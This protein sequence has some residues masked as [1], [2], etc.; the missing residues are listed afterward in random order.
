M[1]W[2]R[3]DWFILIA[4]LL[5]AGALRFYQL[6][7][8]PPGPQFDEAFNAIDAEQIL[9][10]NRPLFLPANAGREPL[11][12]YLQAGVGALF[13]LNL[14]T[15]RLVSALAGLLTV[16]ALYVVVRLLFRRHSRTLAT[17]TALALTVSLWHIHFS[18][19]GIRVSLMPL[20]YCGLFG[21]LWFGLGDRRRPMRM[22][23]LVVAG[24][25]AGLSVWTNPTGR[26]TPFI[27][28]GYALYMFWRRA[29]RRR[30]GWDN[31]LAGAGIV[32]AA[33]LLV[34]L[35][36]GLEFWRHPAFFFGHAAEVSVF[37]DR[38]SGANPAWLTLLDHAV[39]VLGMFSFFGDPE[40]IHGIPARPVFDWFMA[41]PF[42]IGLAV[43][44]LRLANR[45]AV[46]PDPD[47]DALALFALWGAVMLLPSILSDAPPNFSRTLPAI[48]AVMLAAG[49]GL[50]WIATWP[51]LGRR[52]GPIL[53]AALIFASGAT[54]V[55][56]YFVRFANA[57][58]VYYAY[59]ADK[60]DAVAWLRGQAATATVLFAPL[61]AEHP[62]MRFLGDD[63]F[64]PVDVTEVTVLP[65]P[66]Q[67]IVYAYPAEQTDFVEAVADDWGAPVTRVP[68]RH[69]APLLAVVQLTAQQA[70]SWPLDLAP[71]QMTLARFDD[72]PTLLGMRRAANGVGFA[73]YWQ[74]ET[75]ML[76]DLT[77]L[78]QFIDARG[79]AVGQQ[80]RAP[81]DQ[82][83]RTPTWSPG[84]QVMQRYTPTIFDRCAGGEPVRVVAA[85][86]EH[87]A[88]NQRRPRLDAPGDLA[89][90]GT[91]RL[92]LLPAAPGEISAP[93]PTDLA[94]GASLAL[95]GFGL[96]GQPEP[97]APLVLDLY[98][99]G[100][101]AQ[102][103]TPLTV[104]LAAV[105][106]DTAP[107]VLWADHFAPDTT[108]RPGEIICRRAYI[109]V[110]AELAPG[111][112]L[113]TLHAP[114]G[115]APVTA[116]AVT[117][118]TRSY[119]LPPLTEPL[120]ATFA[121]VIQLAGADLVRAGDAITVTLGWQAL[122]AP[123]TALTAFVHLL[124][125]DGALVAQSDATPG[126]G[127]ATTQWAPGEAVV[128][129]HRLPLPPALAPGSYRLVAGLYDPVTGQRA[130]VVDAGGA[131]YPDLAAPLFVEVLP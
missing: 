131:A 80:D 65:A 101:S 109:R 47:R 63:I 76:R 61:W 40:W 37:A 52:A 62:T 83:Y 107:V 116:L 1:Q 39:R 118:A 26:F 97:N 92:P 103:A 50:T 29:D 24:L 11:Y 102:A 69:G 100:D 86:Y 123:P 124:G 59:D 18:H 34:F 115:S 6:G 30:F 73:L 41:V 3:H 113:L 33:A 70:A 108:W 27:V 10:G 74:A 60:V 87:L 12:S 16:A 14:S 90:A 127:Y 119:I 4:L 120:D 94:L 111:A 89:V 32:G 121:D 106:G 7:V 8:V 82:Y 57:P 91:L 98:L 96:E 19:Y 105:D 129:V 28:L 55:Y 38:V 54:A 51:R 17:T 130:P 95:K 22:T 49:L 46:R 42:Y 99:T 58:D 72:A 15:L 125:P 56:D 53:A 78:V 31:P 20:I 85:W 128:D 48:P 5:L 36:L 79:R 25:L 88:D 75:P 23:A 110:P 43:W 126:G 84:E 71:E 81:G 77:S 64:K 21:A 112:H 2:T 68:D 117:P 45:G 66:G 67:G 44:A 13:G 122:D 35:P 104:T 114:A 93:N 9:A